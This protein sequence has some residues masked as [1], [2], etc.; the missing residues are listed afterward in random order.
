MICVVNFVS[1][2]PL[3]GMKST[4]WTMLDTVA[5]PPASATITASSG[6]KRD[7]CEKRKKMI[8]KK[9]ELQM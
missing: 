5:G 7:R 8:K 1:R 6:T 9:T 3:H 2:L 4:Y